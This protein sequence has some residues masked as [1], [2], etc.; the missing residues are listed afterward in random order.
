MQRRE[1]EEFAANADQGDD[2]SEWELSRYRA[3]M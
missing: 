2:V 1:A 3:V